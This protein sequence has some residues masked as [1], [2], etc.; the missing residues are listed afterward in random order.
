MPAKQTLVLGL[1]NPLRGDDGL[2]PA[3]IRWMQARG[4]PRGVTAIDGGTRGLDV[5]LTLAEY[6]RVFIVD[7]AGV[8]RAPG[9]WLRLV[10]RSPRPN[11]RT[12]Q[13]RAGP[14]L[15]A[16]GVGGVETPAL[17]CHAAGLA[18]AL[19]LGA[20]LG[21]LP[22]QVIIFGVQPARVDCEACPE[23]SRRVPDPD[24]D[25][26]CSEEEEEGEWGSPGLSAEVRKAVPAV[27]RAILNEIGSQDGQNPDH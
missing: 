24:F 16:G 12:R 27:G 2:G 8:G 9:E 19:A 20:A 10:L 15:G 22:E 11:P 6:R 26:E 5:L 7:A 1:G 3:V 4:L 21:V 13:A 23:R 18:D 17:S 25:S 14:L